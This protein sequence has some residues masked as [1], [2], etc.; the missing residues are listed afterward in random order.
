MLSLALEILMA[1]SI[2]SAQPSFSAVGL[3]DVAVR[4]AHAP[5][6]SQG[7]PGG[8]HAGH[9]V[10]VKASLLAA[11]VLR[12]T[13]ASAA[14]FFMARMPT[15]GGPDI[16]NF[17]RNMRAHDV[18][19]QIHVVPIRGNYPFLRNLA[20]EAPG[21]TMLVS[22][23][24][25]ESLYNEPK[26]A[27][28]DDLIDTF[29][30]EH[31]N[32]RIVPMIANMA[33]VLFDAKLGLLMLALDTS[34]RPRGTPCHLITAPSRECAAQV[35]D[36]TNAFGRPRHV[37]K[38]QM[39]AARNAQGNPACYDLD[40]YLHITTSRSGQKVALIY[41]RC[42]V[43]APKAEGALGRKALMLALRDLGVDIIELDKKDFD[44]M[45]ANCVTAE[46]GTVVFTAQVSRQLKKA[47]KQRAIDYI[48]LQPRVGV[49]GHYGLH[50][51]TLEKPASPEREL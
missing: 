13:G 35:A 19:S 30:K 15:A 47:L 16:R 28:I 25:L 45:A 27:A 12:F 8:A 42:I 9:A 33:N 50:C 1:T 5:R 23:R 21:H 38:F 41:S 34:K 14:D 32:Y 40:L 20:I 39:S 4:S 49:Q 46:P 10:Q 24:S 36:L 44:A 51:L 48:E 22:N 18:P 37:L 17:E 29:R 3:H 7:V 11:L 26:A 31:V 2:S 43:E 6:R